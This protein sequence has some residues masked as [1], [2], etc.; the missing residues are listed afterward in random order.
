MD[1]QTAQHVAASV[2]RIVKAFLAEETLGGCVKTLAEEAPNPGPE[3]SDPDELAAYNARKEEIS[4]LR[5]ACVRALGE[6]TR[7][8]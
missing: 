3:P 7:A 6:Y 1:P 8:Q 2:E 4:K 5:S